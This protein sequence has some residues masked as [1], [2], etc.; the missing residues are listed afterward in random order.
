M[1]NGGSN[2]LGVRIRDQ[3]VP[4]SERFS[5]SWIYLAKEWRIGQRPQSLNT[6]WM[7][8]GEECIQMYCAPFVCH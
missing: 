5:L 3:E 2:E 1:Q 7:D 6:S 4:K 8:E